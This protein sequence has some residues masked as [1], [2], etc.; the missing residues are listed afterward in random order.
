MKHTFGIEEEYFLVDAK[1]YFP[2][3]VP[4]SLRRELSAI[5]SAGTSVQSELLEWQLEVVTDIFHRRCDALEALVERRQKMDAICR[6]EGYLLL[7][8][9]TPVILPRQRKVT[10]SDRYDQI[11]R[12]VPGI[13]RDH[14]IS[15]LHI[16]IGIPDVSVGIR[17]MN[18]LRLWLPKLA[19]ISA[20]SP[21]WDGELSGFESWRTVHYR[22]WSVI[23]I[24]PAFVDVEHYKAHREAI[25]STS[26]LLDSRHI[27]WA[28]RLS[29][30]HPTI[31]IRVADSQL[32]A[33]E[34][35]AYAV[36]VRALVESALEKHVPMLSPHEELL[37]L[38]LWQAAKSGLMWPHYDSLS[39][40]LLDA[41]GITSSLLEFTGQKLE[42]HGDFDYV[43]SYFAALHRRGNGAQRQ[44][45]SW[46]Q[47]GVN[48]V[49]EVAAEQFAADL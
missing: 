5:Q 1:S 30:R 12:F 39:G 49:A 34:S 33:G 42:C 36:L 46:E 26:A 38:S 45:L 18:V 31:E 25:L 40:R 48:L 43:Q 15:G 16:H 23:G 21:L 28:V 20:N 24:P 44:R 22:R 9:G 27:G 17:A 2:T 6:S 41:E 10:H 29:E 14:F 47:G 8:V 35:V 11:H 32:T 37:D 13:V 7:A 4:T 3:P 19:A